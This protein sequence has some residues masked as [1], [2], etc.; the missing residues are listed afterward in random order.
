MYKYTDFASI[1]KQRV[2]IADAVEHYGI[3]FNRAGF[4]PCP[5]HAERT[6]SFSIK[7]GFGYCYGCGWHGD[8]IDLVKGLCGLDFRG[9]ISEINTAFGLGLPIDRRPTLREQ[10][11]AREQLRLARQRREQQ[12]IERI[13]RAEYEIIEGALWAEK[14][15]LEDAI[16]RFAPQSPDAEWDDRF[17]A[18]V[19]GRERIDRQIDHFYSTPIEDILATR[20]SGETTGGNLGEGRLD[21][22]KRCVNGQADPDKQRDM[23][24]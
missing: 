16:K 6:P 12:R 13:M 22:Q 14:F 3:V 21:R 4:A 8:V 2:T 11:D 19:L 20:K 24:V 1:L 18:A 5:F 23:V 9:A 10:R 15:R 7:N 17:V